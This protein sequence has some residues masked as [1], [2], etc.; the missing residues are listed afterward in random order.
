MGPLKDAKK[1]FY[2]VGYPC[3]HLFNPADHYI[4]NLAILPSEVKE[5]HLKVKQICD[6]FQ[7]SSYQSKI[8]YDYNSLKSLNDSEISIVSNGELS[9]ETA[10]KLCQ[11][12]WLLWR[13]YLSSFRDPV[14]TKGFIIQTLVR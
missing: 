1:F 2:D 13:Q 3:P 10:T 6:E 14:A 7:E 4:Q 9:G 8:K 11:I 12:R 5:S